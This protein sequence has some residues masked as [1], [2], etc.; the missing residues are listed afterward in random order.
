MR[1][2]NEARNTMA[3]TVLVSALGISLLMIPFSIHAEV[4]KWIDD[5]GNSHFTDEYSNIPERYL[6]F[7][8]TQEVP[9][10]NARTGIKEE[11]TPA[12][13]PKNP[14]PLTQAQEILRLFSGIISNVDVGSK[15]IAVRGEE[16]EM[17]FP[18]SEDSIIKTEFGEKLALNKLKNGMRV[19][20]EYMKE[21]DTIRLLSIKVI[22]NF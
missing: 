1:V 22:V 6:P 15:T 8:K 5:K 3:K 13:A 19:T 11:P 12:I 16:K 4:Y 17:V 14:E 9:R 21:G 20:V 2:R 18:I 10:E 7:A